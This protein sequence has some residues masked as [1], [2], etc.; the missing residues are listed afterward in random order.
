MSTSEELTRINRLISDAWDRV[1]DLLDGGRASGGQNV[2]LIT[3][4][5]HLLGARN[6]VTMASRGPHA[7]R[8]ALR[9]AA[10]KGAAS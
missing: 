1:Q 6:A 7:C 10:A 8:D 9:P 4:I 5:D 3:A 2:Y